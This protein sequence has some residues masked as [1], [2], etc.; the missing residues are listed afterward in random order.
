[1]NNTFV[2]LIL[3]VLTI[4]ICMC[5]SNNQVI[6][7]IFGKHKLK[8]FKLRNIIREPIDVA[9]TLMHFQQVSRT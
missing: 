4:L 5:Q 3:R 7:A 2:S 9:I 1:M 8:N 6:S